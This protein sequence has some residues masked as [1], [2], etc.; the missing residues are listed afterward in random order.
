MVSKKKTTSDE[1]SNKAPKKKATKKKAANTA[2]AA[3]GEADG[4]GEEAVPKKKATKKKAAK[5]KATK[6]KTAKKQA[7]AD[8]GEDEDEAAP[9]KGGKAAKDG[10]ALVVV[11]SPAKAKTINKFLGKGYKVMASKGHVRDLPKSDLGVDI[12]HGFEPLY[13]PLAE[14]RSTIADLRKAAKG[15]RTIYLACDMDREGEAIAWHVSELLKGKDKRMLRVVFNQITEAAIR[16][17]FEHPAQLD[18][19]KVNA[20]QARRILDRIVGYKL[21]QL[22]WKKVRRGLSAG[23]VQSVAVKMVV[24]REEEIQAFVPVEYWDFGARLDSS[25]LRAGAPEP[26]VPADLPEGEQPPLPA[27]R[28]EASMVQARGQKLDPAGFRIADREQ[29]EALVAELERAT[30]TVDKVD[31]KETRRRPRPPFKTS[32]LQQAASTRLGFSGKK[33]MTLAQGLYEGVELGGEG[34]VG[35]IT[36]MRTDSFNLAPEAIEEARVFIAQ[37]YGDAYLP[38]KPQTYKQGKQK[39]QAQ[40]AHEAIRPTYVERTPESLEPF[41]SPDQL[42]LYRLIWERFVACQ[43]EP[44]RFNSLTVDVGARSDAS[45]GEPLAVFRASG[46]T[47]LFD[48]FLRVAGGELTDRLLPPLEQGEA[49]ALVPPLQAE[50]K[51]TRPPARYNEASLIKKLEDEGIGRPSTYAAIISTIQDR[52]YVRQENRAL[53]ATTKGIVVTH[54]LEEFFGDIMGYA[55]TRDLERDLDRVEA[56]WDEE[57]NVLPALDWRD[58]L[59]RFYRDFSKDLAKATAEMTHVNDSREETEF[60][61]PTCGKRMQKLYN[62]REFTQFLGCPDYP[63]CKTTVPLDEEGNP[64]PEEESEFTC[65]KCERKLVLKSGRRGRFFACSGYPDCSQTFDVGEDGAP[66]PRPE[67]EADCPECET[68]MVVRAGRRGQFLG[69]PRYPDCTGTLPLIQRADGGWEVGEKGQRADLPKV[70]VKCERCGSPMGIKFSRR[71]PFLGCTAYPKC[72]GTAQLPKDIELPKK[73]EPEPYGE[74]CDQCGKP[75]LVRQGR[76]GPFVACSGYPACRNTKDF[77]AR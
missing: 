31:E 75:L 13:E 38:A 2:P 46:R 44:A 32:D 53:H 30:F 1:T 65:P 73:K 36:Y 52:G 72:K 17:A 62:T 34:A 67:I 57:D 18:M 37:R 61:C 60:P 42:K 11:E 43:M 25:R 49:L 21:S 8:E 70:D 29:A 47:L 71:G 3:G 15:A 16:A 26:P 39:V 22:L 66:A 55:Y 7:S 41:L 12:D 5:K 48:G 9:V 77:V 10:T 56:A 76:R 54:K 50:Q 20:Q 63:E 35:L 74:D 19:N 27:W 4:E 28:F 24:E 23:R 14:K 64:L 6:K 40:E 68:P 58:L 33:T 51:F 69:C 45:A 59:D